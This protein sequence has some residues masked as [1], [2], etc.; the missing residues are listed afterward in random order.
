MTSQHESVY[1]AKISKMLAKT[2]V[3]FVG[4]VELFDV[5]ESLYFKWIEIGFFLC[6][7]FFLAVVLI[8]LLNALAIVD[9][10]DLMD[11]AAMDM[12]SSLLET[13][14]FWENLKLKEPTTN[15]HG[16]FFHG[17][18]QNISLPIWFL[19]FPI[20]IMKGRF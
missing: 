1:P 3:M 4:E 2:I 6:F 16:H 13:V 11:D 20:F 8:N 5:S 10:K 14:S 18:M 15:I 19:I 7:I 9:T 17:S 12:L